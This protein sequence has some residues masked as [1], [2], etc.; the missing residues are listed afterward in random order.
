MGCCTSVLAMDS[1]GTLY[2][3][4]LGGL[5]KSADQGSTWSVIPFF[6]PASTL[7][8]LVFDPHDPGTIYAADNSGVSR[9]TDGA[10]S[11][12]A[13]SS[14]IRAISVFSMAIDPKTPDTL[15]AGVF[16]GLF[17]S[18]DRG[19]SW[20]AAVSG[21]TLFQYF[22]SSIVTIAIDPKNRSNLYA[23]T[24]GDNCV[25]VFRSLDAGMT[26]SDHGATGLNDCVFAITIDPQNPCTLYA[27]TY[28]RGLVK[29]TDAGES[30]TEVTGLPG[31]GTPGSHVTAATLPGS[32]RPPS[33]ISAGTAFS[34]PG[35]LPTPDPS[36]LPRQSSSGPTCS[37]CGSSVKVNA[38]FCAKCGNK[39]Q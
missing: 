12:S 15:Y 20:A 23:G 39:I 33:I 18:T 35:V 1:E 22:S 8:A 28:F 5:F 19:K 37:T 9:S 34:T 16:D 32:G 2:A 24:A 30:W 38:K 25:G 27:V 7:S 10:A 26:W 4:G 36:L 3:A 29:S 13:A 14:G 6:R 21:M 17:K 11:W 31:W